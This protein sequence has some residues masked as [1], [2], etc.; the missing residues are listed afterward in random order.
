[1]EERGGMDQGFFFLLL[2]GEVNHNWD[3]VFWALA[4]AIAPMWALVD[5]DSPGIRADE[6]VTDGTVFDGVSS[7]G[8][9]D[10]LQGVSIGKGLHGQDL[11]ASVGITLSGCW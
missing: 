5:F 9:S 6:W 10:E 1:M 4:S 8:I 11:L 7:D 2:L 3:L